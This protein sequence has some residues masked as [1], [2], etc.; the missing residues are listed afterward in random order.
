MLDAICG[1]YER[2]CMSEVQRMLFGL[3]VTINHDQSGLSIRP[4]ECKLQWRLLVQI[5]CLLILCLFT[6][7]RV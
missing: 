7:L 4:L 2:E 6:A 5:N 1:R 3:V